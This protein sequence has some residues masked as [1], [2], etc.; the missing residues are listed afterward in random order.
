MGR[1]YPDGRELAAIEGL[2][3]GHAQTRAAEEPAHRSALDAPGPRISHRSRVSAHLCT[4]CA[5]RH[6]ESQWPAGCRSSVPT[7]FLFASANCMSP[8]AFDPLDLPIG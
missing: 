8:P 5:R 1:R 3:N 7:S 4:P 2:A 6:S